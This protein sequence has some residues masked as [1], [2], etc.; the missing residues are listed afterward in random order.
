M[1]ISM[2]LLILFL[3]ISCGPR[4]T[5]Q[6][7]ANQNLT[8][9]GFQK[10]TSHWPLSWSTEFPIKLTLD[11]SIPTNFYPDIFNAIITWNEAARIELF[12][13]ESR[14]DDL[15]PQQDG[16]N[17]ISWQT[18]WNKQENLQASTDLYWNEAQIMEAD[19]TLNAQHFRIR[20]NPKEQDLDFQ[21]LL[22][23]ELGHALGLSHAHDE[24]SVMMASLPL[25][26]TRR[27]PS[28]KDIQNIRCRYTGNEETTLGSEIALK[29]R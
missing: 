19:I 2:C 1:R 22:I 24:N 27:H 17:L 20:S 3:L 13:L 9:Q 28:V 29:G 21:S 6:G 12:S 26:E 4:N 7:M 14:S 16:K 10:N 5:S 15:T 11:Q 25:G 8:C 18:V 23:H